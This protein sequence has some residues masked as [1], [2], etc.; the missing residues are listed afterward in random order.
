VPGGR[1]PGMSERVSLGAA[2]KRLGVSGALA[3]SAF[4]NAPG[5]PGSDG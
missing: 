3:Q 4:L 2:G 1:M 5:E